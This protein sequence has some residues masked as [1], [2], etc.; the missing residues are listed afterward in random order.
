MRLI[1]LLKNDLAKEVA[2]WVQ[3]DLITPI[4]ARNICRIYGIDYD[5][6]A[7]HSIGYY[8]LAVLGYLFIGLACITLIGANW[9]SIPRGVR[10]AGLIIITLGIQAAGVFK[11]RRNRINSAISLFFLGSLF[12]GASIMLIA[13]V[14]H[15][16]EHYPDGILWWALGVLPL[17]LILNSTSLMLL[18]SALGFIWFFTETS[19]HY[20]PV[21]FPV[22][23][24]AMGWHCFKVKQSNL[25]FLSLAG[26]LALFLEYTLS[27]WVGTPY[28]FSIATDHLVVGMAVFMAYYAV[29]GWMETK[30]SPVIKDYAALLSVW[31]LRFFVFALFFLSFNDPWQEILSS[32]L[33]APAVTGAAASLLCLLSAA[34]LWRSHRKKAT[35]HLLT[36]LLVIL[37]FILQKERPD[38][39]ALYLQ[40]AVNLIL[41]ITGVRLIVSGIK[42]S[43]SH[44]FFIGVAIVL[45]TGLCRYIDLVGDYIGAA[46]LFI[47]FAAILL[48]TASF[49]KRH[50]RKGGLRD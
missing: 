11:Y 49:W 3:K 9:E 19:L 41:I 39:W 48:A 8:V 7:R 32:P 35:G 20:F 44:Y 50:H 2:S 30:E 47:V 31:V 43:V 17:G 37:F 29:A 22:F 14:Y 36:A 18:A 21:V 34:V 12:Y 24:A 42:N 10:M 1:R 13:Q 27:W 6:P 46:V 4:Q 5:H 26:G 33:K 25:L 28:R 38:A 23:L 15:I 40:V 16:G 45:I